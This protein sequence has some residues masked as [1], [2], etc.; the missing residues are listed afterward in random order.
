MCTYWGDRVWKKDMPKPCTIMYRQGDQVGLWVLLITP[1]MLSCIYNSCWVL[2]DS[3]QSLFNVCLFT[4]LFTYLFVCLPLD[5]CRSTENGMVLT[6]SSCCILIDP[7]QACFTFVFLFICL[8]LLHC[9]KSTKNGMV[10][11][12][13]PCILIDPSEASLK[14]VC[15]L[16]CLFVYL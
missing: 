2:I 8:L 11:R 9:Y 5:C 13:N 6:H 10:L 3:S 4:I 14:F 16:I 7:S 12:H 1:K 15:L